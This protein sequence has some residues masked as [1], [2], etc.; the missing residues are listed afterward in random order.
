M[1]HLNR[2]SLSETLD[3]LSEDIFFKRK[4][5]TAKRVSAANWLARRQGLPGSYAGMFAPT[6]LDG[7]GI[8][9]FTGEIVRSRAGIG[10]LLGEECCRVL[11]LLESK[12]PQVQFSLNRAVQ[13][14]NARLDENMKK[15]GSA[16]TY[17]CG[18]CSVGY[19]RSLAIHLFP[20]SEDRLRLGLAQ[21]KKNR[22][23]DGQWKRY[24]F[25]F[26][27]LALIEIGPDLAKAEMLHAAKR[28]KKI[29]PKFAYSENRYSQRRA[30]I[31]KRLLELCS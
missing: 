20:Q 21:L 31:G 13:G 3:F 14:M 15:G 2:D 29:L 26:T 28:W 27:S 18:T 22:T 24:P 17:C 6:E 4:I 10:H 30:A 23:A 7:D 12:E 1:H 11:T 9:L 5:P 16:G 25:Y 8:R 19:W